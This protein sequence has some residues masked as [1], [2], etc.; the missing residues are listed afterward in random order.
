L[1][2]AHHLTNTCAEYA[3]L[4]TLLRTH[5]MSYLG[6]AAANVQAQAAMAAMLQQQQASAVGAAAPGALGSQLLALHNLA[7]ASAATPP[8]QQCQVATGASASQLTAVLNNLNALRRTG[9]LPLVPHL[10]GISPAA[11]TG[12]GLTPAP[13]LASTFSLA[14]TASLPPPPMSPAPSLPSL[15]VPQQDDFLQQLLLQQQQQQQAPGMHL[16]SF[17]SSSAASTPSGAAAAAAASP[18]SQINRLSSMLAGQSLGAPLAG[19]GINGG[20]VHSSAPMLSAS[21]ASA[22][23]LSPERSSLLSP[24]GHAAQGAH[25]AAALGGLLPASPA[26]PSPAHHHAAAFSSPGMGG[27]A[28]AAA[29]GLGGSLPAHFVCP[30]SRQ[31]MTDPV[32]AADGVTYERQAI[33][34]WLAFK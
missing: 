22:A 25:L 13:S 31:V 11:A 5:S 19:A 9:S 16:D 28:P 20:S 27:A 21:L 26:P 6:G 10:A 14:P 2:S 17:G 34:D 12:L 18:A 1:F 29:G 15:G 33:S 24:P 30:L 3:P 4:Q 7:G 23:S 32:I 8:A